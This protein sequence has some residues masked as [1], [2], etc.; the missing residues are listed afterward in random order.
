MLWL[1]AFGQAVHSSVDSISF[2][3]LGVFCCTNGIRALQKVPDHVHRYTGVSLTDLHTADQQLLPAACIGML[4][5]AA[6][7]EVPLSPVFIACLLP[8]ALP[9]THHASACWHHQRAHV[10][11]K[12]GQCMHAAFGNADLLVRRECAQH[13][14]RSAN[15]ADCQALSKVC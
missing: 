13:G 6:T 12:S 14:T 15:K 7:T 1:S 2:P 8:L 9:Y 3:A 4:G 11:D 5:C 10:M